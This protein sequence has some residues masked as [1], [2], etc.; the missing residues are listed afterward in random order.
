MERTL[1]QDY[2]Y[3]TM[4]FLISPLISVFLAAKNYGAGW[5][6]NMVWF[7]VIFYAI[8]F[9]IPSEGSDAFVYKG[10]LEYLHTANVAFSDFASNFYS[11]TP[12]VFFDKSFDDL[13]QPALTY[14]VAQFTDNYR[15][16]YL[17]VGIIFGY[18]YSRNIWFLVDS[19]KTKLQLVHV[20]ILLAFPLIIPFW[21]L[22][23]I[24]MWT[25]AHIFFYGAITY[26]Y[27]E[28][29]GKGLMVIFLSVLMH[30]SFLLPVFTFLLFL[31]LGN[32]TKIF[33]YLFLFSFF[34]NE[35]DLG[36]LRTLLTAVTPD[37]FHRRVET[38]TPG[39][40]VMQEAQ[41]RSWQAIY[42]GKILK[43]VVFF[44]I[45]TLYIYGRKKIE[46]YPTLA[47]I[48]AF[49]LLILTVGQLSSLVPSGGRFLK[50]GYLFALASLFY[51]LQYIQGMKQVKSAFYLITP[52]LVFFCLMSIKIGF[53]SINIGLLGNLFTLF[54]LGEVD[55]TISQLIN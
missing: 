18:F 53:D 9:T 37:F 4:V 31:V 11:V 20:L 19:A 48:F 44:C 24:R 16:L 28:R 43:W 21:S 45:I 3:S 30:F 32:R 22:N 23:S 54:F 42:Y 5:A 51:S 49:T 25:A 29:K 12:N 39:E 15:V 8:S 46:Q 26:L 35:I 2:F 52:G 27:Y 41:E 33:F 13:I 7:F 1:K 10:D 47:R 50:V 55:I 38:Y 36:S 6:K 40:I 14:F 17:F 34:V